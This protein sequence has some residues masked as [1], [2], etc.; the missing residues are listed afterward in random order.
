MGRGRRC[1]T[2]PG[3]WHWFCVSD[4]CVQHLIAHAER[5]E[6]Q[7]TRTTDMKYALST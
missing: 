6:Q 3:E 2:A 4:Q 1:D 7:G 5:D